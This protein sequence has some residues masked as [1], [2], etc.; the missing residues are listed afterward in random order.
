MTV[1]VA[2]MFHKMRHHPAVGG[3][4]E[5]AAT[6]VRQLSRR[7]AYIHGTD[8]A[9]QRRLAVLNDLT[10]PSFID[11]LQLKGQES[12]L[13]VGSGLGLLAGEIARRFPRADV[14]GVEFSRN[15]LD[16]ADASGRSNL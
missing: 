14:L 6:G 5:P 8:E 16:R 1:R 9:E 12:I 10:N 2:R 15:Q 13:E 4:L 3:A 11:F 7:A